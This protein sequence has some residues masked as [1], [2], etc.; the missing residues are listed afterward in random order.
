MKCP[1]ADCDYQTIVRKEMS[2]HYKEC[3]SKNDSRYYCGRCSAAPDTY[4]AMLDH[5]KSAHALRTRKHNNI[6][7][8]SGS[9]ADV[10]KESSDSDG[11]S[12]DEEVETDGD[13]EFDAEDEYEHKHK[14][15]SSHKSNPAIEN[16]P[17]RLVLE[18][19]ANSLKGYSGSCF[20]KPAIEWTQD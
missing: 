2:K 11:P 1:E 5:V 9:E 12:G 4:T 10:G 17:D 7:D 20:F 18:S 3:M 16:G 15:R 13:P 6:F 8:D 19:H 14:R